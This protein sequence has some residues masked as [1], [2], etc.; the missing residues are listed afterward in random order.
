M[1]VH[2]SVVGSS[3]MGREILKPCN[4][5]EVADYVLSTAV[6]KF[7]IGSRP[8]SSSNTFSRN[9]YLTFFITF[10]ISRKN[11]RHGWNSIRSLRLL[12][13]LKSCFW[14]KFFAGLNGREAGCFEKGVG[15]RKIESIFLSSPAF[16][17]CFTLMF[18]VLLSLI[19]F[20]HRQ[21]FH[22][23]PVS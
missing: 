1:W 23:L 10:Y 15:K 8:T 19:F 12:R 22:F 6:T 13:H 7:T 20:W 11:F 18:T 21:V 9:L 2:P 14:W 5:S 3:N 17:S 16:T 4:K